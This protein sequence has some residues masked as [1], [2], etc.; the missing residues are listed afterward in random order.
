MD[1]PASWDRLKAQIREGTAA[2]VKGTPTIFL[3]GKRVPRM[4]DFV[5]MIEKESARLGLP[6]LPSPPPPRR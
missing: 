3:N 4:N 1:R 2:G 5:A 6:P